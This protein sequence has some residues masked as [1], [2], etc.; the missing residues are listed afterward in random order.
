M[1][2]QQLTLTR[3]LGKKELSF[4]CIVNIQHKAK[5]SIATF[6][7][8]VTDEDSCMG[9]EIITV[10]EYSTEQPW[11]EWSYE[12][13]ED[14]TN[15]KISEIIWHP[16]TLSDLCKWLSWK[17][18]CWNIST[19]WINNC[20]LLWTDNAISYDFTKDLLDQSPE[21]LAQIIEIITNTK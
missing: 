18:K 9:A 20:V 21:T 10:Y 5:T 12:F 16:A 17:N 8:K 15:T 19:Y 3:L 7:W 1:N 4:G 2:Q 6:L 14:S 11:F 13:R